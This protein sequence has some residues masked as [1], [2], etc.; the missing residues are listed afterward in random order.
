MSSRAAESRHCDGSAAV[1][2]ANNPRG[3]GG[4][5]R[6]ARAAVGEGCSRVAHVCECGPCAE[7]GNGG[8]VRIVRIVNDSDGGFAT[9]RQCPS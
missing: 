9:F 1:G 4:V 2:A 3:I 6:I 7:G 5:E 8:G